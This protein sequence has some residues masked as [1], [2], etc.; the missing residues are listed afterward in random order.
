MFYTQK[1]MCQAFHI[2]RNTLRHYEALGIITPRIDEKNGYR[3]YGYE[4]VRALH[5]CKAYQAMGLSL[6][7][8]KDLIHCGSLAEQA[9]C[10]SERAQA[11]LQR[12]RLEMMAAEHLAAFAD[13]INE[14]EGRLGTFYTLRSE[15]VVYVGVES[16]DEMVY[17]DEE[18]DAV[19]NFM[20][21]HFEV[22]A[23]AFKVKDMDM[24]TNDFEWGYAMKGTY[25]VELKGPGCPPYGGALREFLATTVSVPDE[26]SLDC[27]VFAGLLA[28]AERR[29]LVVEG[30]VFGFLLA[31]AADESGRRVRYLEAMVP[32]RTR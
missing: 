26:G 25:Y 4:E 21:D 18:G 8:A 5:D 2:T 11:V 24:D 14:A 32:V 17:G 20:R 23:L 3:S 16:N 13:R 10:Y 31:R 29:G 1:E 7:E 30:D 12:A 9:R 6:A 15:D 27:G 28:E 19:R 22:C